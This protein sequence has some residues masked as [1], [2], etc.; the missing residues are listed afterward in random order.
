[1]MIGKK[2]QGEKAMKIIFPKE[3]EPVSQADP[4]IIRANGRYY[5]YATNEEGVTVYTSDRLE[6]GWEFA[7]FAL[8]QEGHCSFWAPCVIEE[9][10]K[11]YMYYSAL[12][13]GEQD[14]HCQRIKVAVSDRPDGGF[15]YVKDV[16]A[17]FSIDPHVVKNETGFYMFYSV[18]DYE[19]ARAGTY[20]VVDK[21]K[22][23]FTLE[24]APV[25]VVL[26]TL[27][28]EIF[29]RDRFRKGQHWHTIEGAFYFRK[30]EDH[31]VIYS[32]NCYESEY[33]FL[34]YAYAN[35][36]EGDLRKIRFEKQP[37]PDV[38]SPLLCRDAEEEGTGHNSVIEVDGQDYIVYHG[39]DIC[40]RK[41]FDTRTARICRLFAD[42]KK[43]I[44]ERM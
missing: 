8:R 5:I 44:A 22:D 13:V 4:Y 14:V 19:A 25:P 21:M 27:D 36:K 35:S 29:C 7:G 16:A 33:Y 31:Y 18:N 42:G 11:F 1:M 28:E 24:G 37:S 40:E 12:P 43:L 2:K 34:G 15:A 6:S 38:Y 26:P 3:G 9:G 39:R 17:P 23:L 32:G 30:G 41:P 10:G 20:I